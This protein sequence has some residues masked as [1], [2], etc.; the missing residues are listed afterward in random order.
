M[1]RFSGTIQIK[2]E[3]LELTPGP[4]H[5]CYVLWDLKE[6]VTGFIRIS[7]KIEQECVVDVLNS[8]RLDQNGIPRQNA[9]IRYH[10]KA[11][12]YELTTYEP[13]FFRYIKLVA[14]GGKGTAN[15]YSVKAVTWWYPDHF[16]GTFASS[17]GPVKSDL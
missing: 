3:G 6:A 7:L 2:G 15:I 17:D 4:E 8:D 9:I 10:L 14:S 13:Y 12:T 5:D 11:G 1:G 16:R